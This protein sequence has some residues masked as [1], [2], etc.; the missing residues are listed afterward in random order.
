MSLL[1]RQKSPSGAAEPAAPAGTA[2]RMRWWTPYAFLAPYL[3]L[4]AVFMVLPIGFGFWT[5][6][7]EW[8]INLPAKPFVGLDNYAD[9]FDP[10]GVD[11]G[12]FW[13]AMRATAIFTLFSVPLLIVLPLLVALLMNGRFRGRNLYR[14]VYFAPYVLG[15]AV[16]GFLWRFLLDGNIGLVN[17]YLGLD[18]QWTTDEPPVWVALVGVTVWWTLGLNAVI[19]LAGLQDIPR[20]LHEA[21]MVDGA[22]AWRRFLAVTLPGLRPVTVFV[23]NA[24]ILASA[25]MFGQ[26]YL[27][28]AGAPADRT[29]T[30]IYLIAE[31]GLRQFDMG[32]ASAMSFI[33]AAFLMAASA[34]VFGAFRD[35]SRR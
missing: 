13:T 26:S 25:N 28:T 21:A 12:R 24:T 22:S 20:E 32:T 19:F 35:R 34:L 9:L 10:A 11:G 17:H 8:D 33:L 29:K 18:V 2:R 31:T 4:F 7:H 15:V 16:V 23:V 27:I 3:T 14:A 5:S 6:L 1:T 30:A